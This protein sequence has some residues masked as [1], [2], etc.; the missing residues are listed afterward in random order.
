M[1]KITLALCAVS[2]VGCATTGTDGVVEIAPNTYMLGGMGGAFDHSG[3]AVKAKFFKQAAQYCSDKGM[4]M[5]PL[6][7]TGQDAAMF[8]H[9]SAEVQFRCV[10]NK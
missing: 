9:A 5:V 6:N 4:M 8:T 2:L 10:P 1:K 3:S 7:S